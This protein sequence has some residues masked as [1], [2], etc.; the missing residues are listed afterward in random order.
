MK[1]I[2][3]RD[4][5]QFF[6]GK[7]LFLL[8]GCFLFGIT[9]RQSTDH[10]Y[11]QFVLHMVSEHYYLTYFMIPVFLL[12]T[13][14]SLEEDMDYVLIRSRFYWKYFSAKSLAF[15]LNMIG[16]VCLQI[17][18]VM[19]VGIGLRFDNSFIVA[20]VYSAF[21]MEELFIQYAKHFNSPTVA[22]LAASAYMIVG[23]TVLSIFF[24]MLHHFWEKRIVSIL[25]ISSY[26]L[27][28]MGLKIP[29]LN[30]VPFLFI[31]NYVILHYNFTSNGKFVISL[32]CMLLMLVATGVL[33]KYCWAKRF[34]L[35]RKGRKK[36]IVFYYARFLFTKRNVGIMTVILL[37]ISLWKFMN[38]NAMPAATTKDFLLSM[39]Y[40][41]GVDRFHM[42]SFLEMLILNGLPI[43]LLAVF[44]ETINAEQNLG[45]LIRVK[46]KRSW[47][48]AILQ[49]SVAFMAFYVV[50]MVGI[51]VTLC[52]MKGLPLVGVAQISMQ[53]LA[54][55]FLEVLFQFLAFFLLF[56][57]KRNVTMAFLLVFGS[58]VVSL[59]PMAWVIYF[60]T[61]LS[62]LARSSLFVG[63]EGVSF[64]MAIFILSGCVVCQWLYIKFR[65][66]QKV[67]GG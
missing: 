14:K 34:H 61:G 51:G 55:K 47:T 8:F 50:L 28:T 39:F 5:Q 42:L 67:L 36:G 26:I 45:L 4:I 59:L 62:S 48:R 40:G 15:L 44:V 35:N 37:F 64:T 16:F 10:S 7:V 17:I 53:L 23:L 46:S 18:V 43:Y 57:W 3:L 66:Y 2:V 52:V 41:H 11:E 32:I 33:I 6:N 49:I 25:M 12:F 29:S 22:S 65:G 21:S 13:Y 9:E 60:P 63:E 19:I 24:L 31:N 54:L 20:G 27:M 30:E 56:L 38:V 1:V 58:N